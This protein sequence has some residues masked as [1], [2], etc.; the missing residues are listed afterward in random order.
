MLL[1]AYNEG[2]QF[3]LSMFKSRAG[4]GCSYDNATESECH[5][6]YIDDRRSTSFSVGV[7]AFTPQWE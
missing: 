5:T 3:R 6:H 1:D 2:Q 4:S 7:V